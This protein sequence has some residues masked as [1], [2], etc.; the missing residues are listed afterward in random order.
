MNLPYNPAIPFLGIDSKINENVCRTYKGLHLS[1]HG[2][3]VYNNPKLENTPVLLTS[4]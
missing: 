1:V 3:I 4:D 2:S